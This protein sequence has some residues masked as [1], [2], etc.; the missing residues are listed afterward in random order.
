MKNSI[1]INK[2]RLNNNLIYLSQI[3]K[4][5]ITNG[6]N[7][8]LGSQTYIDSNKWILNYWHKNLKLLTHIDPIANLWGY[9]ESNSDL[10]PI[11]IG[12]HHDA[13]PNGGMYDG[14]LGIL[15]ATEVIETLKENNVTLRHPIKI[16]SFTA[17]E[18][19]PY[20]VSTLGSKVLSRRLTKKQLENIVHI[21][22]GS[23]LKDD[24]NA[25]GGN[26][27]LIDEAIL[28]PSDV[29]AFIEC[30]IEQGRRLFDKNLSLATVN[31]IIG[32][33]RE[34][35]KI[36]GEANHAGTTIMSD[37][38]DALLGAC[39][40]NIAFEKILKAISSNE[41]VGTIGYLSVYPNSTNIIPG[42][43]NLCLEIR[44]CD[45]K[46][47]EEIIK[48]LDAEVDKIISSRKVNIIRNV[49]LDQ[50]PTIMDKELLS[51]L[52]KGVESINEP[53]I[54]FVSMAGHDAANMQRITK[55]GMIF[56]QSINGKSH[57]HDENT[58][59]DDIEKAGNALLQSI[60]ILDKELN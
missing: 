35:I 40:L 16:V 31:T 11:L 59:I 23:L 12:S 46:I 34:D 39:E 24:I 20:N 13:V 52:N 45:T 41:I 37:R 57:C 2:N 8:F 32:I 47:K 38:K 1:H 27:D 28:K 5:P 53:V 25:L 14:A 3:G 50:Y 15:L 22:N 51:I 21:E 49:N 42:E 56:V 9:S 29:C 60:L 44:T 17:E 19:N 36:I 30:H 48:K 43:V 33:Y 7:R 4:D 55:S 6:I 26:F 54:E 58:H 10:A 18:P